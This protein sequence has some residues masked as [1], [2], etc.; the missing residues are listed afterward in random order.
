MLGGE[1]RGRGWGRGRGRSHCCLT[2]QNG[3]CCSTLCQALHHFPSPQTRPGAK[4][5]QLSV[6]GWVHPHLQVRGCGKGCPYKEGPG[7][8]VVAGLCWPWFLLG[9]LGLSHSGGLEDGLQC[10]PGASGLCQGPWMGEWSWGAV[11]S[12]APVLCLGWVPLRRC[13]P[14]G[15]QTLP[16]LLG[17]WH[18]AAPQPCPWTAET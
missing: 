17:V 1:I 16:P 10:G 12:A 8:P 5:P 6:C 3:Q 15:W 14:L 2:T 11:S 4:E 13:E 7:V 18:W 9:C